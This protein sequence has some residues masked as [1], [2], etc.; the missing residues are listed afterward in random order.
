MVTALV[1][2]AALVL[3]I[4][5]VARSTPLT[6]PTTLGPLAGVYVS[7]SLDQ[8]HYFVTLHEKDD[9][10]HGALGFVYQDGQTSVVFTFTGTGAPLGKHP[11]RG[12]M[13][14]A[15]TPVMGTT[16]NILS[17]KIPSSISVFYDS[18]SLAFGECAD[19]LDVPS[20]ARCVFHVDRSNEI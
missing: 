5:A 10:V 7:G 17:S 12:L 19:Y 1:A 20:L 2:T 14:A 16:P 13:V 3:S 18:T 11:Q 15:T 9:Q 4:I 8:P 6:S